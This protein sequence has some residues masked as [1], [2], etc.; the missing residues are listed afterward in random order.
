MGQHVQVIGQ[1]AVVSR[2]QPGCGRRAVVSRRGLLIAFSMHVVGRPA[3]P[4]AGRRTVFL[5]TQ[6]PSSL[7][8][9]KNLQTDAEWHADRMSHLMAAHGTITITTI[10]PIG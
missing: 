1:R 3:F 6:A 8:G 2:V 7:E 4:A 9:A 5:K 10:I